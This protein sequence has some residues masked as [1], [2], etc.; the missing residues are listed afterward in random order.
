MKHLLIA[1]FIASGT[2]APTFAAEEKTECDKLVALFVE[3]GRRS[4]ETV[5]EAEARAKV[6]S[7]NPT[8]AECAAMLALFPAQE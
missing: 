4:G 8:E 3:L 5:S 7:E 2:A 6:L 1:L